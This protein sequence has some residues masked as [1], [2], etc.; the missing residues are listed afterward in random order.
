MMMI[1]D[2]ILCLL[3]FHNFESTYDDGWIQCTRCNKYTPDESFFDD[4]EDGKEY[5]Q[6]YR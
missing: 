2:R 4:F 5:I 3:G 1:F 6:K